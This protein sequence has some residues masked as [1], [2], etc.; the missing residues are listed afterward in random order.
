MAVNTEAF[1]LFENM[2]V[3]VEL[4]L[5]STIPF[6]VLFLSVVLS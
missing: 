4:A 3:S 2:K 6:S 1:D 5:L